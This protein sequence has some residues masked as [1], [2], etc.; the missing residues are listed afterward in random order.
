MIT[1]FNI[2]GA[3]IYV[4]ADGRQTGY[5]DVFTKIEMCRAHYATSGSVPPTSTSSSVDGATQQSRT[6]A[7]IDA[8]ERIAAVGV[9]AAVG[10][11]LRWGLAAALNPV[12]P[13]RAARHA[14]RESR[15]AAC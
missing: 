4:D 12:F 14:G 1:F 6:P 13:T 8:M 15:S 2:S 7:C 9:G 10:A 5:E 3:M 11:W